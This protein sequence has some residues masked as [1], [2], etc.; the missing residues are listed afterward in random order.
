[1]NTPDEFAKFFLR[2]RRL[3]EAGSAHQC[4][5]RGNDDEAQN[6]EDEQDNPFHHTPPLA[7]DSNIKLGQGAANLR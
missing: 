4:D 5:D 2:G 7:A 3:F 1:M 6:Q